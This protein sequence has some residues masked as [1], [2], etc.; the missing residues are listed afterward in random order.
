MARVVTVFPSTYLLLF[1]SHLPWL[2]KARGQC[3]NGDMSSSYLAYLEDEECTQK[4]PKN[5]L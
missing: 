1:K 3:G 5:P 2:G 4:N